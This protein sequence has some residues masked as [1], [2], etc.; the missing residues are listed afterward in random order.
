MS[1]QQ[2]TFCT[3]MGHLKDLDKEVNRWLTEQAD[4]GYRFQTRTENRVGDWV[5]VTYCVAQTEKPQTFAQ[6][7]EAVAHLREPGTPIQPP[8]RQGSQPSVLDLAQALVSL[9]EDI[10]CAADI[11]AEYV[12]DQA[13]ATKVYQIIQV[14][15]LL[16]EEQECVRLG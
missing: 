12:A 13:Q 15:R 3:D 8:V 2:K 6:R 7:M 4:Y 11:E 14:C 5:Y 1:A 16:V 10:R 9:T